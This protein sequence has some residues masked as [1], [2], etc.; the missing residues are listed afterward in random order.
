MRKQ[1]PYIWLQEHEQSGQADCGCKLKVGTTGAALWFCSIHETA[2]ELL[3]AL[4]AIKARIN[5]EW[6]HPALTKQGPL[7]SITPQDILEI[8]EK[9]IAKADRCETRYRLRPSGGELPAMCRAGRGSGG[10]RKRP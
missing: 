8:A 5:G 1:R 2:P 4:R 6:D 10:R 9:A 7:N 3:E